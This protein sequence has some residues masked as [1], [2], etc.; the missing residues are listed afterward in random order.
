MV[1][2]VSNRRTIRMRT[3]TAIAALVS[4]LVLST[5]S[6]AATVVPVAGKLSINSGFGFHDVAGPVAGKV[7]DS[8]MAGAKSSGRIVYDDGCEVPVV[9]GRVVTIAAESPCGN[10]FGQADG[11]SA[12]AALAAVGALAAIGGVLAGTNAITNASPQVPLV[13][14]SP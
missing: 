2:I 12:T 7:G 3:V 13:P 11:G 10:A 4:G 5:A 6:L 1:E 14:A 9:P 8:V